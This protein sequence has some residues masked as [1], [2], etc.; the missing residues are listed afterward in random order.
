[1]I[2][3]GIIKN[4]RS[5]A[6][7]QQQNFHLHR[8]LILRFDLAPVSPP[9]TEPFPNP[10]LIIPALVSLHAP[11]FMQ[12]RERNGGKIVVLQVGVCVECKEGIE[13]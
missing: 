7:K 9:S 3:G 11:N 4:G 13:F 5:K 1:M 12:R 8:N 10:S 6:K 2:G